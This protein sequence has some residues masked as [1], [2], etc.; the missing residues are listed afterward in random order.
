MKRCYSVAGFML[1][2]TS[3]LAE[4]YKCVEDGRTA[5]RERLCKGAGS[6]ITVRPQSGDGPAPAPTTG[7]I[8]K[9]ASSALNPSE[10]SKVSHQ[11][12]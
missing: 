1:T 11:L 8:S 6:A 7:A 9:A 5:F 12:Q 10:S 2:V 4:M 3:A